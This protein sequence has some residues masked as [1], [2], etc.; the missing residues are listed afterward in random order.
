LLVAF[1]ETDNGQV[2]NATG[3]RSHTMKKTAGIKVK[4]KIRGGR[5]I[6]PRP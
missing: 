6:Y 4:S 2:R 3:A 5:I 1:N